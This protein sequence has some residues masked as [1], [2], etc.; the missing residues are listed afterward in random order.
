MN[1]NPAAYHDSCENC[2]RRNVK[3]LD[4]KPD[5]PGV[6]AFY[7]CPNCRHYWTCAWA[8]KPATR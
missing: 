1:L 3:P 7:R 4:V 8:A 6:Q 5:G 2:D